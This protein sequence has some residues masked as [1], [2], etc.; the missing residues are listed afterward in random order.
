MS[1]L[2]VFTR[3]EFNDLPNKGKGFVY[4]ASFDNITKVG[5]T[6]SPKTRINTLQITKKRKFDHIY[7]SQPHGGAFNSESQIKKILADFKIKGEWFSI[8]ADDVVFK[9]KGVIA[10]SS[11]PFG[12]RMVSLDHYIAKKMKEKIEEANEQRQDQG[13]PPI[14]VCDFMAE[15]VDRVTV[16]QLVR[17]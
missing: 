12:A 11:M 1:D 6:G 2:I 15:A 13:K 5:C 8:S 17:V 16:A 3:H 4:I 9:S 14:R 7:V 10:L